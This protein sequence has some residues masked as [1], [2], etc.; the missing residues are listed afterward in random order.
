MDIIRKAT[1]SFI[2]DIPNSKFEG[3]IG[4]DTI[5]S[6]ANFRLDNQGTTTATENSPKMYNLQIQ[7]NHYPDIR[8]LKALAPQ[9]VAKALVS[10]DASWIASQVKDELSADLE[11]WL[12]AQG[13]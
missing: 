11:R 9:S 5:Y 8:S 6:D 2:E 1:Y 13:F 4:S 12:R 10:I 3:C 7:V